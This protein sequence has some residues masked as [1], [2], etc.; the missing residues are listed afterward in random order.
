MWRFRTLFKRDR[1]SVIY[2]IMFPCVFIGMSIGFGQGLNN[3]ETN[4]MTAVTENIVTA[5][6]YVDG[7]NVFEPDATFSTK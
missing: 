1:I 6:T 7:A 5:S 2:S 4:E 3:L